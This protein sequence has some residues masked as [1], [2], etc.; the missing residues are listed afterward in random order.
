[1]NIPDKYR[2]WLLVA[3]LLLTVAAAASV[4]NREGNDS[5]VVLANPSR[6]HVQQ[7]SEHPAAAE[8]SA[9]T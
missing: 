8:P 2:R 9:D 4:D 1:M 5:Q 3:A 6:I 7:Q